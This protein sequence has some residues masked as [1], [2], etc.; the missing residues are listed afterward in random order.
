MINPYN[1]LLKNANFLIKTTKDYKH[2][3]YCCFEWYKLFFCMILQQFIVGLEM[4]FQVFSFAS[5]K[6]QGFSTDRKIL[7]FLKPLLFQLQN[8]VSTF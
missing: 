4:R 7:T 8:R 6:L 1:C 5:K 2:P 3:V